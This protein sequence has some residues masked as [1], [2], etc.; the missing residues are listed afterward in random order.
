MTESKNRISKPKSA[1]T[2]QISVRL[3]VGTIIGSLQSIENG[4]YKSMDEL[5]D[6]AIRQLISDEEIRK[7]A[8]HSQTRSM[9]VDKSRKVTAAFDSKISLPNIETTERGGKLLPT[10]ENVRNLRIETINPSPVDLMA[11]SIMP[12]TVQKLWPSKL[13][14]RELSLFIA[15]RGTSL[16]PLDDFNPSIARKVYWWYRIAFELDVE[17]KRP[18][19]ERLA[20]NLPSEEREMTSLSR[21]LSATIGMI[22]RDGRQTGALPFL[23]FT[24]L[25]RGEGR[26]MIGITQQGLDFAK[27]ENPIV[28]LGENT[29]PPFSES[30]R[31]F[32]MNMIASRCPM[33][34]A[35]IAFYL[36]MLRDQPGI[37]RKESIGKMRSFYE[38]IWNPLDLRAELI[39]SLRG[40]VN[41]RSLELGLAR[42]VR[43]EKATTYMITDVGMKWLERL[44]NKE[45]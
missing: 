1:P 16:V 10:A 19:G 14:L 35:H 43:A 45:R 44:E 21:F 23:G 13:S 36:S 11:S 15:E 5:V 3:P 27:I 2:E 8:D 29:Y 30:E 24:T 28:D 38:R 34:S 33:E 7:K 25:S 41:S 17:K 20:A 12:L 18:R 4:E 37:D 6:A 31:V 32:V 40:G 26:T 9:K 39:D 42:T 22:Y